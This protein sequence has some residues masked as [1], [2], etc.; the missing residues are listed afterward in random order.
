MLYQELN[1]SLKFDINM[2][3]LYNTVEL[4][5]RF[6]NQNNFK[7]Y[8]CGGTALAIF[9]KGI[10]RY[11]EDLE[12]SVDYNQKDI[13]IDFLE[14]NGFEFMVDGSDWPLGNK[15]KVFLSKQAIKIE[16]IFLKDGL[17]DQDY[18]TVN[19]K[20]LNINVYEPIKIFHVK[21]KY[22]TNNKKKII[23]TKDKI[24]LLHFKEYLLDIVQKSE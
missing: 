5:I 8:I 1:K 2:Q 4:L 19:I 14:K 10:Y 17:I 24:D 18:A 16:I 23:R 12:I 7:Y 15:K 6:A 3:R 13:W 21:L 22:T 9:N 20:D 11:N